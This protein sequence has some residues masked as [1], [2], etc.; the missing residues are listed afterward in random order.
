MASGGDG[1]YAWGAFFP[2][3]PGLT[4]SPSGV[5]AGVPTHA[6]TTRFGVSVRSGNRIAAGMFTI[7]VTGP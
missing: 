4:L 3:P 6:G 1:I 7:V 2:P 5:L